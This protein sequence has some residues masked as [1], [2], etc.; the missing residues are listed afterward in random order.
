MDDILEAQVRVPVDEL[1]VRLW[2]V[3]SVFG[4]RFRADWRSDWL[5]RRLAREQG[6]PAVCKCLSLLI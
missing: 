1:L 4:G 2:G 5:V 6:H 3:R